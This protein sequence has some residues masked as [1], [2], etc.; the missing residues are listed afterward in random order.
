MGI[1]IFFS[2][3]YIPRVPSLFRPHDNTQTRH[4]W[5]HFSGPVI[6][7]TQRTL[8]DNTQ[9][10]QQRD[11]SAPVSIRKHSP[12]KRETAE[13]R[14]RPRDHC[15]QL[16][17]TTPYLFKRKIQTLLQTHV[18][19]TLSAGC[20]VRTICSSHAAVLVTPYDGECL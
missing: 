6:S 9:Y 4:T 7:L 8:P 13:P 14:L 5:K 10:S 1:L 20:S 11:I 2:N 15:Y 12:S 3:G 18:K 16:I 17:I 19:T